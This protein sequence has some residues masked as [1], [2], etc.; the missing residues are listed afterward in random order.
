[1][2]T[3]SDQCAPERQ[4]QCAEMA[5]KISSAI[6]STDDLI[7]RLTNKL[8]SVLRVAEPENAASEDKELENPLAPLAAELR[9]QCRKIRN[10]NDS[11]QD[12]LERLEN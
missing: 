11:I 12:I 4:T 1:M 6:N 2:A 8:D 7:K 9:E 5:D 3:G 10:N